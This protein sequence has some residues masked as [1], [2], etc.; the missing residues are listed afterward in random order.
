MELREQIINE[1]VILFNEKGILFNMDEIARELKISKKT[2][3]KYFSSKNDLI[4]EVVNTY[5]LNIRKTE[6]E[7]YGS[8]TLSTYEKIEKVL[9]INS[10]H[11]PLN[12]VYI[13]SL[14]ETFPDLYQD[15]QSCLNESWHNTFR[16][17]EKGMAQGCIRVINIDVL[18]AMVNGF[19]EHMF[20]EK[21]LDNI[22]YHEAI[23]ELSSIIINGIRK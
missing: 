17:L 19:F 22:S 15:A 23:C 2:I 21:L 10:E 12:L 7:I 5:L 4:Q 1:A 16:L 3:Y 13:E 8:N 9:S 14:K 6:K 18:K 11:Y 20:K